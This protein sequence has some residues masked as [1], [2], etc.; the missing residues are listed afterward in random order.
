MWEI[1][2]NLKRSAQQFQIRYSPMILLLFLLLLLC[3]YCKLFLDF[4]FSFP[5][6]FSPVLLVSRL[7]TKKMCYVGH[8]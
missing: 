6:H 4:R 2:I 5:K 1:I 7:V 3:S 8:Y